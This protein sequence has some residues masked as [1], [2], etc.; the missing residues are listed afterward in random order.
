M[1]IAHDDEVKL[2]KKE[3][4]VK[5]IIDLMFQI[6]RVFSPIHYINVS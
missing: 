5:L 1:Q 4:K 2:I 3:R 6:I